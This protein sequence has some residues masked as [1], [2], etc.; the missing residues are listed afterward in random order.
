MQCIW[1]KMFWATFC[2][3]GCVHIEMIHVSYATL[4]GREWDICS[5]SRA[6]DSVLILKCECVLYHSCVRNALNHC[7]LDRRVMIF[8]EVWRWNQ[9]MRVII[10]HFISQSRQILFF[11][12]KNILM[13]M[14]SWHFF[15]LMSVGL[16]CLLWDTEA[17]IYSR[18]SKLLNSESEWWPSQPRFS[19]QL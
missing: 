4:S 9:Q 16:D 6:S 10:G 14:N 13:N 11:C 8:N 17:V 15:A 2:L 1:V 19:R 12:T 18:M 7:E 3:K 5:V